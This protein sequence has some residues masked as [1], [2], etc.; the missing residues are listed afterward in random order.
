MEMTMNRSYRVQRWLSREKYIFF[1]AYGRQ[2]AIC[3]NFRVC[4]QLNLL[5]ACTLADS[6]YF[7]VQQISADITGLDHVDQHLGDKGID[8]IRKRKEYTNAEET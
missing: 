8:L 7:F 2:P 6:P 1:Q 5:V 4:N 3:H